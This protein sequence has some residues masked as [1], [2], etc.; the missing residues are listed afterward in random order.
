MAADLGYFGPDSATWRIHRE[1]VAMVG[2]LRALLLQALHPEA[3]ALLDARSD[4][5]SDPWAR[6]RAT[7]QYV[8]TVCFAPQSTVD[9]AAQR[10]RAVHE[11][12]GV[13][14]PEQLAWVHLCLVDSFLAA[15]AAAGLRLSNGDADRYV[16]EQRLAAALVG[17]PPTRIPSS[18]P[19][20]AAAIDAVRPVL[21]CTPAAR[22]AARLVVV[23]PM[24]VPVRYA[25]AARMGW[26]TASGLA[27]GLLP[28]WA[29]RMYGLPVLPGRAA[30]TTVGL[31]TVRGVV[32]TLPLRY[33]EGPLARQARL[34]AEAP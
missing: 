29:L 26:T 4:F 9:A 15:A 18:V 8:S 21:R 19:E 1:P 13:H 16:A 7:A 27:V 17:V 2:G 34:R 6:F 30:A 5:R 10:V 23:P 14:D 22:D 20:L 28:A 3:M 11:Q 33:R 31:R 32:G 12:C 24:R 25:V